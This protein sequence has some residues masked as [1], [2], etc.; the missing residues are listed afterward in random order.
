[1]TF[2]FFIKIFKG[3]FSRCLNPVIVSIFFKPLAMVEK[4]FEYIGASV[5]FPGSGKSE[6]YADP[7]QTSKM[8]LLAEIVNGF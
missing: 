4:M 8:E 7:C 3:S 2:D 6:V 5:Y 1:M